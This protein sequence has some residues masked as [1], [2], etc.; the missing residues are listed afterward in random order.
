MGR[1]ILR[2][3]LINIPVLLII[4]ILV[5]A[6]VE[7]APGDMADFFIT[8]ETERFMSEEDMHALREKLGLN[9]PPP[10]RYFKWLGRILQGDLGFSYVQA[11]P[12][13]DLLVVRIK[14]S[15]RM[16]VGLETF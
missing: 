2:R 16:C 12:V 9:D 7:I 15:M 4:T 13:A 6:L 3:I 11:Y 5:F 8:D 14:N 10:I 1:Y